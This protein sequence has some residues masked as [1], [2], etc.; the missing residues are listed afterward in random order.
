MPDGSERA[1][2]PM[3]DSATASLTTYMPKVCKQMPATISLRPTGRRAPGR[4]GGEAIKARGVYRNR[5]RRQLPAHR[6]SLL[7]GYRNHRT[8]QRRAGV[9]APKPSK[10]GLELVRDGDSGALLVVHVELV[11]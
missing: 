3:S 7:G 8:R 1:T 9:T 2:P 4:Q 11:G 5:L 6:R 10:V